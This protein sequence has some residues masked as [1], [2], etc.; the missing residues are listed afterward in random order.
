M[1]SCEEEG[2]RHA[3][4]TNEQAGIT[5]VELLVVI[6]I[7]SILAA[8]LLPALE[9]AREAAIS[10][11]C[12]NNLKQSGL[13]LHL[14]FNDN[15]NLFTVK[16]SIGSTKVL[17]WGSILRKG[18]YIE[19]RSDEWNGS[20]YTGLVSDFIR[21]PGWPPP[22]IADPENY[23]FSD[24]AYGIR[25]PNIINTASNVEPGSQARLRYMTNVYGP[26]G[27]GI[28]Y[29]NSVPSPGRYHF[30]ADSIYYYGGEGKQGYYY[31]HVNKNKSPYWR[32]QAIHLRH[33]QN[34]TYNLWLLDGHVATG[35]EATINDYRTGD[36]DKIYHMI[37]GDGW[38]DPTGA[39][40]AI[41]VNK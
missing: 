35:N 41:C 15:K 40:R 1:F 23:D 8:M 5:L 24:N 13:M 14:Y 28:F 29:L 18:G 17:P 11:S 3:I 34:N 38:T 4:D 30:L 36:E 33:S 39:G 19:G 9:R 26:N 32:E 12:K 16:Q 21:C 27:L 2:R 6:A 7:I 20:S 10:T 37:R 22:S 25:S 31:E